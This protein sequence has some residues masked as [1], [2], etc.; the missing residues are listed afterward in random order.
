MRQV[1]LSQGVVEYDETGT[2][3][4]VVLLHGL[5]MNH[6]QWDRVVPLLPT[7][8]RYLRPVLPLGA[9]RVPMRPD[10][11]LSLRGQ[12]QLLADLLQALNLREVT[13]VHTDWGGGLFLT[14]HGLDER[15]KRL[16]LLPCE[17]FDNFP[18]GLPGRMAALAARV[19][20]GIKLA[21][22][23]LRMPWL[24]RTP[25][26]FGQL[27][28]YPLPD[29][30]VHGWTEPAL[31]NRHVRR[32]LRTYAREKFDKK[33]LIADT[34]ALAKFNGPVLVLWSPENV[35]MP[36]AHGHQ[37]AGLMPNARLIEIDDAYVLSMLDQPVAVAAAMTTFLMAG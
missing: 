24:R 28:K 3:P 20:G 7:G 8:F 16:V 19:P 25:M 17:A 37:L 30:L 31:H 36:P 33:A 14:A 4:P 10:A 12:V 26:L 11:D 22:H 15:V 23:Q 21:A 32:D 9:H 29:D 35:V 18:P 13:L 6:T 2:G 1:E 27:A 5:F 34:E